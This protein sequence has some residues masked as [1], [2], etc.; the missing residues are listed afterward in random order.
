MQCLVL[1]N[2]PRPRANQKVRGIPNFRHSD[3]ELRLHH[4]HVLTTDRCETLS[5]ATRREKFGK[6]RHS[7]VD[8]KTLRWW[9]IREMKNCDVTHI[10]VGCKTS[11][12]KRHDGDR[13][14]L[15]M[16]EMMKQRWNFGNCCWIAYEDTPSR[17][18]SWFYTIYKP[19]STKED[20]GHYLAVSLF[21]INITLEDD[22]AEWQ[23]AGCMMWTFTE[24]LELRIWQSLLL[25]SV[26]MYFGMIYLFS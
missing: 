6:T 10:G 11:W 1:N 20:Y 7:S 23:S 14:K 16:S 5:N 3:W 9:S 12:V 15:A 25:S 13:R 17:C 19:T 18:R 21:I 26:V 22:P 4:S 2:V 24:V 8:R